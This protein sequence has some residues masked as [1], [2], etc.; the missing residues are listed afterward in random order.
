MARDSAH[1]AEPFISSINSAFPSAET[2]VDLPNQT[3]FFKW[4]LLSV[5]HTPKVLLE[6]KGGASCIGEDGAWLSCSCGSPIRVMV[7]VGVLAE[8]SFPGR[9]AR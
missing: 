9:T 2:A 8:Q 6:S 7:S 4:A 1:W 3:P 5:N